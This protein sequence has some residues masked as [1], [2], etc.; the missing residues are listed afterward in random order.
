MFGGKVCTKGEKKDAASRA[1]CGIC[2][3]RRVVHI[4]SLIQKLSHYNPRTCA[5]CTAAYRFINPRLWIMTS[6]PIDPSFFHTPFIAS[7]LQ[8]AKVL[9]H[10]SPGHM[11]C[12]I[13]CHFRYVFQFKTHA[14]RTVVP[15]MTATMVYNAPPLPV[16][17]GATPILAPAFER[18]GPWPGRA[19]GGSR[20]GRRGEGHRG[21]LR[22]R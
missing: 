13:L 3:G 8:C 16:T 10:L 2:C 6:L 14:S 4:L 5:V 17:A 1:A 21:H 12:V 7:P 18:L 19:G 20:E 22:G 15:H 11:N 9:K